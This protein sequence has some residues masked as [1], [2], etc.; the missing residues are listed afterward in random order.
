MVE[1][2]KHGGERLVGEPIRL[3]YTGNY[4]SSLVLNGPFIDKLLGYIGEPVL[5]FVLA[6]MSPQKKGGYRIKIGGIII[7]SRAEVSK[8]VV[9]ND[10][11]R[12]EV[13]GDQL[14]FEIRKEQQAKKENYAYYEAEYKRRLAEIVAKGLRWWAH[15]E[16][17]NR[18][19]MAN[20]DGRK[21]LN[22]DHDALWKAF[23]G[24]V[25]LFGEGEQLG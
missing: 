20:I 12:V 6:D 21:Q 24:R 4:S 8:I 9:A 2:E 23:E 7:S 25:V 11:Y 15:S 19:A 10:A 17:E 1:D 5:P 3:D 16:V 13:D 22:F 14:D 18:G